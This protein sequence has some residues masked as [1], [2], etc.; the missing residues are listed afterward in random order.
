[1]SRALKCAMLIALFA[2]PVLAQPAS[3]ASPRGPGDLIAGAQKARAQR[4]MEQ[5]TARGAGGEPAPAKAPGPVDAHAGVAPQGGT[6]PHGA[7]AHPGMPDDTEPPPIA[8]ER[9]APALPTGTI[10]VRV[11]EPTGAPARG[12]ELALGIMNADGSRA[13]KPG[14]TDAN[15]IARFND[16]PIGDK[17][18]YR[19]NAPYQGAR[20]SSTPFRLPHQ[21]GGYQVE[22]HRLP[23]TRDSRMVVLYVGA[24]SIELKDDRLKIVQQ[25]RLLNLGGAT[26]VFPDAGTLV[27][28]PEGFMAVQT[29]DVMT[30]QKVVEAKGEGLRVSGS[31]PPG[32]VTLMWGFDLP[33][34]GTEASF[35]LDVP[36]LVFAYRVIS[37]APVGMTLTVQDMPEPVLHEDEGRRMLVTE[38]QRKVG[39]QPFKSVRVALAQIPGPGPGRWIA[40]ALALFAVAFGVFASRRGA[41]AAPS[42]TRGAELASRQ[43][44]LLERVRKLDAEHAEGEVGP[45]YHEEQLARITDELAAVLRE[46]AL[47]AKS[48]EEAR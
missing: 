14:R 42:A 13:S 23:V 5:A 44:E 8:T 2:S 41:K 19:I 34:E 18:A 9:P 47:T 20:Y 16:L 32:E 48:S 25:S 7:A 26:Y 11:F 12:A 4:E 28:L 29:E 22:I 40:G 39:D 33:L 1:M 15:G 36:W 30:D 24:T 27:R 38:M 37:D 35:E 46:A 21:G 3:P 17:Q 43:A 45:K 31:L 10:E 6:S